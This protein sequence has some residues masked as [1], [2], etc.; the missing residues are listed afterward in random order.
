MS[1]QY[2]NCNQKNANCNQFPLNYLNNNFDAFVGCVI[3]LRE[4]FKHFNNKKSSK[5]KT[6]NTKEQKNQIL[7]IE[8]TKSKNEVSSD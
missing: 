6:L 1:F 5:L 3:S 7:K 2:A 8:S 4:I